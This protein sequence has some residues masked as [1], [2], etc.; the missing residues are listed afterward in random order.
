M[1]DYDQFMTDN[2]NGFMFFNE[3]FDKYTKEMDE[4]NRLIEDQNEEA[5]NASKMLNYLI[6][7]EVM[8]TAVCDYMQRMQ[9]DISPMMRAILFDWMF[10]VC[11]EFTLKRETFHYSAN[12]V[13]R[14]LSIHQNVK[15]EELQHFG[16][17]SMFI[18][19]K[20]EKVYRDNYL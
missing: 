5:E 14:F 11:N 6:T 12:Y 8:Y 9:P 4:Q 7:I 19:A 1:T 10:E 17:T 3:E 16:V 2:N 15:K 13:D 20:M 18:A